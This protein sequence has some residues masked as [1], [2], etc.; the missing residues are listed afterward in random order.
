VHAGENAL[1]RFEA[2]LT[3]AASKADASRTL[4]SGYNLVRLINGLWPGPRSLVSRGLGRSHV[5]P[6]NDPHRLDLA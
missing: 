3:F 4:G 1:N 5:C 2:E 6:A